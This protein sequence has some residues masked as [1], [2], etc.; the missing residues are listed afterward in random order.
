MGKLG[1][2]LR[3]RSAWLNVL[4]IAIAV[5]LIAALAATGRLGLARLVELP[6][7]ISLALLTAIILGSLFLPAVRWWLLLRAQS[8]GEPFGRVLWLTW[9]GYF[10]SLLLPGGAG[11]DVAR[12]ILINRHRE[13]GRARALST[14]LADRVLGLYS[15]LLLGLPSILW[16]SYYGPLPQGVA[17]VAAVVVALFLA[18]TLG[19]LGVLWHPT[20]RRVLSI[21]PGAWREAWNHSCENYAAAKGTL[22]LCLG[23]S[24][25]SNGLVLLSFWA[26]GAV[27]DQPVTMEASSLAGVLVVIV[28]CLPISPGGIGVAEVA[29]DRMFAAFGV[30]LGGAMM[31]LIRLISIAWTLPGAIALFWPGRAATAEVVA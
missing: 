17:E 27:L 28:N 26:A 20:R 18:G 14:V 3:S 8:V 15:L 24:L 7:S 1:R 31:V 11:G 16:L 12:G 22:A 23:L 29:A 2:Y 21:L 9:A 13:A 19:I 4:R 30:E 25:I 5:G 10:G 6:L